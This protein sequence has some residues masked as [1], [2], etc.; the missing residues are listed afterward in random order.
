VKKRAFTLIEILVSVMLIGLIS[1]FVASSIH[2]TKKGSKSF[3]RIVK[4]TSKTEEFVKILYEDIL[5]SN[6]IDIKEYKR[7]S[8]LSLRGKNSIYDISYPYTVWLVLK[9]DNTLIR[10]ESAREI[11][12]PIKE[13]TQKYIFADSIQKECQTFLLKLSRDK[14]SVLVYIELKNYKKIL[15]EVTKL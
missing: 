2:Q 1:I 11:K 10:L 14:K 9:R 12:L 3:E 8:I 15:F 6:S 4:K 7:Y 13:E 5:Q